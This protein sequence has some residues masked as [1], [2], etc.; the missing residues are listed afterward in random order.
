MTTAKITMNENGE[1]AASLGLEEYAIDRV[2][3]LGNLAVVIIQNSPGEFIA[4]RDTQRLQSCVQKRFINI[5]WTLD[6][7]IGL[8]VKNIISA[9]VVLRKITWFDY[10]FVCIL[11][12]TNAIISNFLHFKSTHNIYQRP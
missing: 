9:S 8:L 6:N 11:Q 1:Y 7:V 3:L 4:T 2:G 10:M 5:V 12:D